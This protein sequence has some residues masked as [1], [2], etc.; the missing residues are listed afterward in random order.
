MTKLTDSNASKSIRNFR[1]S[2]SRDNA[3]Q[4]KKTS[5]DYCFGVR[6]PTSSIFITRG[7]A[8]NRDAYASKMS[9]NKTAELDRNELTQDEISVLDLLDVTSG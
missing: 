5:D 7:D 4:H 2:Q 9:Y 8:D 6:T 1:S 3:Y